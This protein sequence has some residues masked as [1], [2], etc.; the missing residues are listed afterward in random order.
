MCKSKDRRL[1]GQMLEDAKEV[2]ISVISKKER[3]C[4]GQKF[5]NTNILLVEETE[6]FGENH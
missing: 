3:Q 1:N 4:T 5:E 2:I 6:V